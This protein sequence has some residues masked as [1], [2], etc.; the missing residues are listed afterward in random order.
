[1]WPT[2]QVF[3]CNTILPYR[4]SI[5]GKDNEFSRWFYRIEGDL[6][7]CQL[8]LSFNLS[9]PLPENLR[10]SNGSN[11]SNAVQVLLCVSVRGYKRECCLPQVHADIN[12]RTIDG[13]TGCV[14]E[15]AILTARISKN[16]LSRLN[17]TSLIARC[18]GATARCRYW[19]IFQCARKILG[20]HYVHIEG[21]VNKSEYLLWKNLSILKNNFVSIYILYFLLQYHISNYLSINETICHVTQL[22]LFLFHAR[23]NIITTFL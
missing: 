17:S 9:H 5:C 21:E 3:Q 19:R 2:Q 23:D 11:Q 20:T 7:L 8:I 18:P 22:A 10:W 4:F 15:L 13:I 12:L 16:A 14:I 1:M 6:K